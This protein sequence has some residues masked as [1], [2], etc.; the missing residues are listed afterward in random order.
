VISHCVNASTMA[1][2][3]PR[4]DTGAD[5]GEDLGEEATAVE[6][7]VLHHRGDALLL[8]SGRAAA[9]AGH[10][11]GQLDDAL[12][13]PRVM[14]RVSVATCETPPGARMPPEPE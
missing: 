9:A 7:V 2:P 13:R 10:L 11:E 14:M 5:L 8:V 12:G 3:S 4:R 6:H 1:S